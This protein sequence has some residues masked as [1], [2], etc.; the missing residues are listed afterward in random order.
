MDTSV[1]PWPFPGDPGHEG[2]SKPMN[3]L[4]GSCSGVHMQAPD[5]QEANTGSAV[6]SPSDTSGD[7]TTWTTTTL[8]TSGGSRGVGDTGLYKTA[9]ST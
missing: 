6:G 7:I 2:G 8:A 3:H 1:T 4:K 5:L 9:K